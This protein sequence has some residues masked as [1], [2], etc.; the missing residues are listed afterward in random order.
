IEEAF[1]II[2]SWLRQNHDVYR[3]RGY[4]PKE[5]VH[6]ACCSV[7]AEKAQITPTISDLV[8][9]LVCFETT[10]FTILPCLPSI[11]L[12][13]SRPSQFFK[14]LRYAHH[15]ISAGLHADILC[16]ILFT[17]EERL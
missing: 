15:D 17:P 5:I 11:R 6:F 14:G 7:T 9:F 1:S 4:E 13:F 8:P 3:D 10:V 2:R 12:V 16:P